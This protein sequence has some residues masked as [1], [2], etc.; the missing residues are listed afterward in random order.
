MNTTAN[1]FNQTDA[2]LPKV[3][4]TQFGI[5]AD[6]KP[7]TIFTLSNNNGMKVQITN[8]GGKV[9]SI[10]APDRDG[11]SADVVLGYATYPEWEAGNPYFG[12]LIGRFGNRIA[13]GKFSIDRETYQLALNDGPN[14]LHGGPKFG[15]H[16]VLWGAKEI[17]YG[18][19]YGIE[20]SY[21]SPDGEEGYP[22]NLDVRVV[23]L[24]NDQNEL[25]I[26]YFANTDR[27]TPVNLTHHSF[28]NLRG[29]GSGDILGH[30]LMI[31]A[32]LFTPVDSTLIP[33]GEL[34]PVAGTPFDFASFR[35]IGERIAH[36]DAQLEYGKGYD[37]N[38]VLNKNIDLAG[39]LQLAATVLEPESGRRMDV[40]TTE[41][42][43]Q[44]YSG[45]F[46]DGSD[47]GKAGLRYTFRS[48]FCLE[49]QHFPDSPNK[50]NFPNT[51]LLPGVD[52]I[53]ETVYKFS[54]Y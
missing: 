48:A 2:A 1:K 34:R 21:T 13:N 29:A 10:F 37:H 16:N 28:F 49:T 4:N 6:G 50:A 42:G 40:L 3:S 5:N 25:I 41:P 30:N 35:T 32:D 52:F 27:P 46:L 20:L 36:K 33:T 51:I 45:N 17:R 54:I 12:A 15:F 19:A 22:G 39:K 43:L 24:L 8:F 7:V 53:S 14:A 26:R 18:D 31:N 47:I 9:V 38:F 23:Y 11:F 44:F